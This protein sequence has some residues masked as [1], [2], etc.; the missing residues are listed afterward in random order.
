MPEPVAVAVG[1]SQREVGLKEAVLDRV[2]VRLGVWV[3]VFDED[4]LAVIVEDVVTVPVRLGVRVPEAVTDGVPVTC[5]V[6]VE[7]PEAVPD[8]VT[9]GVPVC[10]TEGLCVEVLVT[11]DDCVVDRVAVMLGAIVP[12]GEPVVVLFDDGVMA[13]VSVIDGV[14]VGVCVPVSVPLGV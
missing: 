11:V 14:C 1:D 10:V 7:E 6:C 5:A 2:A 13:P 12:L 4:P 8:A 9:V 3:I